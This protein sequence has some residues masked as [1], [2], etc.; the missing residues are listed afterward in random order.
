MRRTTLA[1]IPVYVTRAETGVA[2]P[3]EWMKKRSAKYLFAYRGKLLLAQYQPFRGMF[4]VAF[5]RVVDGGLV[6][7]IEFPSLWSK[8]MKKVSLGTD[9]AA[10]LPPLSGES[11]VLKKFPRLREFLSVTA[12]DDGSARAPGRMWLDSDGTAFVITLFETSAMVRARFRANALDDVIQLAEIF[13]A[14]ESP[15]WE[16]DQWARER[17]A[18]KKKK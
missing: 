2:R 14:M 1:G 17:V 12:Y 4:P 5:Q 3:R 10:P 7:D 18:T 8:S 11:V 13:L 9:A 6:D 16:I 15:P